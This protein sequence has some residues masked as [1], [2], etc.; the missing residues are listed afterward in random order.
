MIVIVL[1][2]FYYSHLFYTALFYI[3]SGDIRV[4]SLQRGGD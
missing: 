3:L 1:P 2:V 4:V